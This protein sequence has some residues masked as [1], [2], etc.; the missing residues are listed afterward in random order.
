MLLTPDGEW[1]PSYPYDDSQWEDSDYDVG[2]GA[3]VSDTRYTQS[4]DILESIL[5]AT[6]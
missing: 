3:N 6:Q 5:S 4:N 2:S 1:K